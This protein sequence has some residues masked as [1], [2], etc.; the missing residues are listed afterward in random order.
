VKR[1]SEK[2]IKKSAVERAHSPWAAGV[3][4][5]EENG[6]CI[7]WRIFAEDEAGKKMR[8]SPETFFTSPRIDP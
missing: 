5:H 4:P 8:D 1:F 7:F 2:K 6:E 3:S